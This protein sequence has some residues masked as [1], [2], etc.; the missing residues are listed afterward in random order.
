MDFSFLLSQDRPIPSHAILALIALVL[1]AMQLAMRKG[2]TR[3]RA[4]GYVW[5]CLMLY[6]SISAFFIHTIKLYGLFSPI[7]LLPFVVFVSLYLAIAAARR[8]DIKLHKTFMVLLYALA[9]V[10]TG[11]FTLL[12]G[13]VMNQV[14]FGS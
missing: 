4:L 3:H 14:L 6:V 8:G 5:V 1:G 12:P 7:H 10:V 11:F 13:R 2:G 9:L